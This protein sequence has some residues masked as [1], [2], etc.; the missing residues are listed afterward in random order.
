M[1]SD[2]RKKELAAKRA[3]KAHAMANPGAKSKYA[4]KKAEQRN[5]HYRPGSPFYVPESQQS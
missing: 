5:G 2:K 3:A 4:A 1:K